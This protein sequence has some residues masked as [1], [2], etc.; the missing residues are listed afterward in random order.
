MIRRQPSDKRRY[1]PSRP[2]HPPPLGSSL[3]QGLIIISTSRLSINP[4]GLWVLTHFSFHLQKAGRCSCSSS[5]TCVSYRE[6]GRGARLDARP[7]PSA[8]PQT[9]APQ[10]Q[11]GP[12]DPAK[13]QSRKKDKQPAR[14]RYEKPDIEKL[15]QSRYERRQQRQERNEAEALAQVSNREA[16]L[17]KP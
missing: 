14:R 6:D 11:G 5:D 2:P 9:A 1:P 8:K 13:Q 10:P 7:R 4:S 15:R 12:V 17:R 16:S 3:T